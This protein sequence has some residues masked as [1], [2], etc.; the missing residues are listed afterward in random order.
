MAR[1]TNIGT[2]VIVSEGVS[3][4]DLLTDK[5][6]GGSGIVT[7]L[8][9]RLEPLVGPA[10][11]G[12]GMD[13]LFQGFNAIGGMIDYGALRTV[14]NSVAA[15]S[16]EGWATPAW[17]KL[18][19]TGG[20][21]Q[22]STVA[23]DAQQAGPEL[24]A[25]LE[26][27][28]GESMALSVGSGFDMEELMNS[29]SLQAPIAWTVDGDT[30]AVD[31]VLTR[32]RGRIGAVGSQILGSD[33]SDGLTVIGPDADYRAEVL[34]GGELGELE[35]FRDVVPEAD[36][37]AGLIFVNF[38]TGDGWLARLAAGDTTVIENVEP[39]HAFGASAWRDGTTL[40]ALVRL[41]TD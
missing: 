17:E 21:A 5:E 27:L 34:A 25:D 8:K 28:A 12:D 23:Q 37:A 39:L 18:T 20:P 31:D 16:E 30:A 32:V 36:R 11:A 40:H 14:F 3:D 7:A 19:A 15:G 29:A 6:V 13:I 10:V 33:S 4:I 22:D 2:R 26:T 9:Y 35:S 38:D 41:T 1:N 24:P